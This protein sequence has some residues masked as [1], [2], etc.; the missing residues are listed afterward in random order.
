MSFFK[1]PATMSS[2]RYGIILCCLLLFLHIDTFSQNLLPYQDSKVPVTMRARDLVSRM[3]LQEKI[4]QLGNFTPAIDRLGVAAYGYWNEALH[5]VVANGVTS[6]PQSIAL[7]STWNPDLIHKVADAISDEARVKNNME[8]QGLTYWSPVINMAR[9]P[10]W[11]RTEETYGEDPYLTTRIALNFIRGM[12]G[13]DPRY[14]KTV[15]TVKHFACNNVDSGRH[16]IS[17]DVDERSL[18]E[19][20]LP[21]F[22]A[23]VERGKVFSVMNTYNA[24]NGVP[25]PVNRTLLANILRGE[26]GF[27]GYVVSDCDAVLDVYA[28]HGYVK[29]GADAAALS[30]KSGTDLNCGDTYQLFANAAISSGIL[31]ETDIDTALTRIFM[32]RFLLGEFDPPEMVPYTAIPDSAIDCQ[33][34]RNLAL[35]AAR[36][37]IV[38]LKNQNGILP[39]NKEAIST[40]AVIGP[41]ANIMQLGGYSGSPV[42]SITPLQGLT[43]KFAAPGK[44]IIFSEGC[45]INGP[46]DTVAFDDAVN[47]AR[48]ADVVIFIGGTDLQI[49]NE[50][51]DRTSLDLPGVQDDLI[52]ALYE[53]NPNMV[54][55]LV[56]GFPLAINR[57]NDVIAGIVAAWYN[58]QA[59]GAALADVI[60]GDYNPG[61]KLTSTWYKSVT[62]LPDMNHYDI[63]ENRTYLYF[64]G[65]PL[66]AFGHGL[67][68]T[69]FDYGNLLLSKQTLRPNDSILV[70]ATIKNT[71]EIAGDEVPQLYVHHV[72][73]KMRRPIKELKGFQ[74][75]TLQPGESRTVTFSLAHADLSFYDVSS[76][77]F[78]VEDGSLEILVGGSSDDLQLQGQITIQGGM[79][80]ETYR[81]NPLIR[82]EAE[83]F[84]FKSNPM[85]ITVSEEG[86]QSVKIMAENDFVV[87]R[88]VD[89]TE[90]VTSFDARISLSSMA[91]HDAIM[92]IRL[93]SLT[94]TLA[95]MMMLHA[96][97]MEDGYQ[98]KSC[99]ITGA[100]GIHDLYLVFNGAGAERCK[101]NWFEFRKEQVAADNNI[102]DIHLF[103]NPASSEFRILFTNR[104]TSDVL[105]EI[106]NLNGIMVDSYEE[107]A[108]PAGRNMWKIDIRDAGLLQGMYIV[109]CTI[110]GDSESFKLGVVQ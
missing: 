42:V 14:L 79:V 107:V 4:S 57:V 46:K 24:L 31:A 71:G 19:Y 102:H 64:P 99:M 37:A 34:H 2:P 30:I 87:Y 54:V 49:V 97:A 25:G 36:E 69:R 43:G 106:F 91:G 3:S 105:I 65:T 8:G 108:Y 60:F 70:S 18:R 23:S 63:K 47:V 68:Y 88:N 1:E 78:L 7:S 101:L 94:G 11:G 15:A 77:A 20:Y 66:F 82:I 110:N 10:R 84:E 17:S 48:H 50:G 13:D 27:T 29:D 32:A 81:Q 74:R 93:D 51:R 80:A 62:D 90:G 72:S 16:E 39:L 89:F 56:S 83:N 52:Q 73:S 28:S 45:S 59:A 38:L 95:G 67:S 22:K 53:V 41:N 44:K 98:T 96:S 76:K 104:E 92:E 9:D 61:G 26:W 33:E 86:G 85:T 6:F 75:I 103:P 5:G 58:G 12:Q 55:V 109:K 40:I 100:G 21:A 35:R